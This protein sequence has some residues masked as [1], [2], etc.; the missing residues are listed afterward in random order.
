M[1]GGGPYDGYVCRCLYPPPSGCRDVVKGVGL[2]RVG[3]EPGRIG[4]L[5][6]GVYR[7]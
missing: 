5:S 2:Y 6:G 3:R 1:H 4:D 7:V